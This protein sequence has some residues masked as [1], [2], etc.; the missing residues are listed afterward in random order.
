[1]HRRQLVHEDVNSQPTTHNLA[2]PESPVFD[3]GEKYNYGNTNT[4]LLGIVAEKASH[5]SL[6]AAF[7]KY[8]FRPLG[9]SETSYP[10]NLDFPT[11][12]P[13][14]YEVD[15]KTGAPSEYG[16]VNLSGLGAAGGIVTNLHD[17]LI[18][19]RALGTGSL[20]GN[21]LQQF[22][23]RHSRRATDG[24]EYDRY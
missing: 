9:L 2:I 13:A 5:L 7:E 16:P 3:P 4:L 6:G 14:T 11:P 18:W 12:H 22:R 19:G 24:P 23:M 8:I 21:K 1:R 17:L 10:D 20:I 15:P